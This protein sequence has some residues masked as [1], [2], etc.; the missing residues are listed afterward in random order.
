MSFY[1]NFQSDKCPGSLSGNPTNGLTEKVCIQAEK[2]FDA[3]IKQTQLENY[4]LTLSDL[5]PANP[6]YPLTFIS[7]RST[8]AEATVSNLNIERQAD[9]PCARV[10]ATVSVPLEVLYTDANG[11]D[12]SATA[13]VSLQQDVLLYVPAP[14]IMPFS[15]RAVVSAVAP[16]GTFDTATQGFIVSICATV[17]LKIAMPVEVLVPS[18]GYCVIPPLQEYSQEVCA[19]F[20]ELP[21]YPQGGNG[22]IG[23]GGAGGAC[24]PCGNGGMGGGSCKC[25]R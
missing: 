6:T 16:D 2:I 13:T 1:S 14:S 23:S 11:V 8:S 17:I 24:G 22:G 18:Y 15:V 25:G 12:G 4:T 19:G 7:A 20:F 3:G 10:Q 5:S 21:L 9:K